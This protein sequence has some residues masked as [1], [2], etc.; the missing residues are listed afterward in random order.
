MKKE[1]LVMKDVKF[2]GQQ[3]CVE[4]QWTKISVDEND[5][6]LDKENQRIAISLD[7]VEGSDATKTFEK[8]IPH[9]IL[10]QKKEIAD[11]IKINSDL[12]GEVRAHKKDKSEIA[13]QKDDLIK[14]KEVFLAENDRLRKTLEAVSFVNEKIF[15]ENEVL[16]AANETILK[17]HVVLDENIATLNKEIEDLK[18]TKK[19]K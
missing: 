16:K 7:G 3:C 1:I 6:I 11:L 18:K 9:I 2:L 12:S 17:E 14:Q 5:K 13:E 8:F 4:L 19:T 15:K 10:A